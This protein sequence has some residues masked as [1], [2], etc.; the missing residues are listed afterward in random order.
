MRRALK[1]FEKGLQ[2]KLAE[3]YSL[4]P[5]LCELKELQQQT[6]Q[7]VIQPEVLNPPAAPGLLARL[8]KINEQVAS[9]SQAENL[10]HSHA[11]VADPEV[12]RDL[13]A[14]ACPSKDLAPSSPSLSDTEL[15]TQ[16]HDA[17]ALPQQIE[18]ATA[19]L[20]SISMTP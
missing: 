17:Y 19:P 10:Q 8:F 7:A 5:L 16:H 2:K 6:L 12:A 14:D 1:S 18:P 15:N 9:A 11:T 3:P 13:A 20:Q 4:Y